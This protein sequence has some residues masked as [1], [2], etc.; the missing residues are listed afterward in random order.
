MKCGIMHFV[1]WTDPKA[2]LFLLKNCLNKKKDY[3]SNS[4][5]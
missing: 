3:F 1:S 2:R 4:D 5:F